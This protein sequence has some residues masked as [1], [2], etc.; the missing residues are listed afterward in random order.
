MGWSLSKRLVDLLRVCYLHM[1][2]KNHSNTLLLINLQKTKTCPKKA[3]QQ[4][5][6]V[7]TFWFWKCRQVFVHYLMSLLMYA[8][9]CIVLKKNR[10]EKFLFYKNKQLNCIGCSMVCK[11]IF[12]SEFPDIPDKA[13]RKTRRTTQAVAKRYAFHANAINKTY[14]RNWI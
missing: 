11:L 3:L 12:C 14:K 10:P 1:I 8:T 6:F 13:G 2:S 4:R 5:L 7:L 9:C